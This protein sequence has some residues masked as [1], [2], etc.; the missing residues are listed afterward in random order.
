MA[1]TEDKNEGGNEETGSYI[2]YIIGAVLLVAIIGAGYFL[3]PKNTPPATNAPAETAAVPTPTPTPGPITGLACEKSYYNPV[4]GFA[5]YYLSF[6][7]GD[8]SPAHT[9][10]CNIEASQSGAIVAAVNVESPLTAAPQ[11]NG[12][13][14][15]CTT[16]KLDLKP[17]IPTKVNV[18]IK[19]DLN[20]QSTCSANFLLPTP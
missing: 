15:R 5:Q 6:E 4:I 18:V 10:T 16:K 11:R 9:V 17:N 2:Y 12:S 13:T 14:F 1:E 19:D 7:G 3:R 20:N 8:V